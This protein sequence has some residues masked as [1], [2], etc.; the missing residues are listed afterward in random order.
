MV[1]YQ[2]T[3]EEKTE[4]QLLTFEM[5]DVEIK[6]YSTVFLGGVKFLTKRKICKK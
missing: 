6:I 1:K 3:N 4:Q 2:T 5:V